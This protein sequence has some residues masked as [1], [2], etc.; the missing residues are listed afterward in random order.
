MSENFVLTISAAEPLLLGLS[1]RLMSHLNQ[2]FQAR[3]IKEARKIDYDNMQLSLVP[4]L[5][6]Q[7]KQYTVKRKIGTYTLCK[8]IVHTQIKNSV[9]WSLQYLKYP[10]LFY[11]NWYTS[12]YEYFDCLYFFFP[13]CRYLNFSIHRKISRLALNILQRLN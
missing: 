5:E 13:K 7:I 8:K 3:R 9:T 6:F 2:V 11:V 4:L 10:F 1:S 12:F